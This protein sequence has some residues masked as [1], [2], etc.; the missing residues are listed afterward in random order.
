MKLKKQMIKLMARLKN[1]KK[2]KIYFKLYL[3]IF[4]SEKN[5]LFFL[6]INK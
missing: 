1:Y 6:S 3:I 2:Y 5:F 4:I